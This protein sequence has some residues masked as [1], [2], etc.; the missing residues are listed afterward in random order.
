M[1]VRSLTSSIVSSKPRTNL[2]LLIFLFSPE[3]FFCQLLKDFLKFLNFAVIVLALSVWQL[4]SSQLCCAV[5]KKV[6]F[7]NQ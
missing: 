1:I 3:R 5:G 7:W 6:G 4:I 2:T